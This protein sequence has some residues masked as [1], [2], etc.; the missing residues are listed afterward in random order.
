MVALPTFKELPKIGSQGYP[1]Y[2]GITKTAVNKDAAMEVIAYLTS[3]EVQKHLAEGGDIPVIKNEQVRAAFASKTGYTNINW[4]AVFHH[5]P[6][7]I[8]YKSIY[9]AV[10]EANYISDA[11]NPLVQGKTDMNTAFRTAAEKAKLKIDEAKK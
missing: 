10:V 5:S 7:P 9:D 1:T 6:A 11:A 8:A 4:K 2:F 3:D